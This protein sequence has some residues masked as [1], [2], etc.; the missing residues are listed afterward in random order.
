MVKSKL[1]LSLRPE[2]SSTKVLIIGVEHQASVVVA[3]NAT[4]GLSKIEQ[5]ILHRSNNVGE[6]L[7]ILTRDVINIF[8]SGLKSI[9][10]K[11]TG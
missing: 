2:P 6:I 4:V 8:N 3:M 1:L 10:Y 5:G 7:S 9:S 11:N